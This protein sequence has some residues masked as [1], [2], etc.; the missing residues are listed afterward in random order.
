MPNDIPN[1]T[2]FPPSVRPWSVRS[3]LVPQSRDTQD[4]PRDTRYELSWLDADGT[5]GDRGTAAP[6][7]TLFTEAFTAL[8]RGALILPPDGQTAVED[9]LPG[10]RVVTDRGV[11][12]LMW[13]GSRAVAPVQRSLPLFR[14]AADALGP[15]RPMPDLLLGPGARLVSR[16]TALRNLIGAE[17]AL[18]PIASLVDGE[19]VIQIR[20]LST[21]QVYHLG[22]PRHATFTANGVQVESV[23]P[24]TL[25]RRIPDAIREL[26]MQ[27]FPHF[28]QPSD[29]GA[30]ALERLQGDIL[31]KVT[32]AA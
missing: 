20:P 30:L 6:S 10:D 21:V 7:T 9:L 13:K 22:F 18:I 5:I 28:A 17:A 23:H 27:L 32:F 15:G 12:P 11:E 3:T 1:R 29:F 2:S 26:Y 19:A 31:A 4:I 25:D 24:G 14:V 8:A 16:R